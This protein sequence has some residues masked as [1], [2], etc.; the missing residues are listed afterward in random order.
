MLSGDINPAN[1]TNRGNFSVSTGGG[2]YPWQLRTPMPSGAKPVKDGGWLTYDAGTGLVYASRGN[3]QP[4]FFSYNPVNDSWKALAP[5]PPGTEGKMPG[6]GSAGC[7]DGDGHVYATKGNNKPGFWKY[8]AATNAWSQLLDV[9]LGPSNKKVK[10]GTGL[11]FAY[12]GQVGSPYLLKGYKNEF[13]RYDIATN[14]WQTLPDAPI[15]ANQKWD[16]GS[17]L[18][19]DGQHTLYAFKAKYMEFYYYNTETDSWSAALA[20]MPIAGSTGTKKAKDGSC[21]TYTWPTPTDSTGEIYAFKGGNTQQWWQYSIETN[22]WAEKETIPRGT[23]KKKVKSGASVAAVPRSWDRPGTPIEIPALKGNKT[24][25]LWVY[26]DPPRGL[27]AGSVANRDG[28]AAE[29]RLLDEPFLTLVPNPLSGRF[30]TLRYSLLGSGLAIVRV[31]DVTGRAVLPAALITGRTGTA[32]LDLHSLKAGVY[33]LKAEG[34]GFATV[35]KL[36]VER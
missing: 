16:K 23:F 32:L 5:W 17:W 3:K 36:V 26:T 15:G 6:K 8:D 22:S 20:P 24:N 33:L 2:G 11:A 13:Y 10:G 28:V 4:D 7:A 18:V 9:P 12:K 30:V 19:S 27:L 29:K 31:Y 21:G 34:S 35:R 1:D 25:E 14:A